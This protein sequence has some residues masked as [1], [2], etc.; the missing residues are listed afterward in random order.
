[1]LLN[2]ICLCSQ[3][4]RHAFLLLLFNLT[5]HVHNHCYN[6]E[7]VPYKA[8]KSLRTPAINSQIW[9]IKIPITLVYNVQI[10]WQIVLTNSNRHVLAH[11][12]ISPAILCMF[13]PFIGS[14]TEN[15]GS[16]RESGNLLLSMSNVSWKMQFFIIM[17][18]CNVSI[19]LL[20]LA[21]KWWSLEKPWCPKGFWNWKGQGKLPLLS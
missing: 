16:S 20:Q 10:I 6:Y 8:P 1:M 5:M 13:A 14:C 7:G 17:K 11:H 3:S 4:N 21:G 15:A 12:R 18:S 9:I 2:C 19:I